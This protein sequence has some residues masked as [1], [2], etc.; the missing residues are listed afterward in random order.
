MM[1]ISTNQKMG[2]SG[3]CLTLLRPGDSDCRHCSLRASALFA[4]LPSP[5]IGQFTKHIH[6]GVLRRGDVIYRAGD[7]GEAVFTIRVGVVKLLIE[8]PARER[9]IVR[10][11]G[12]GAT[13]GLEALAGRPYAHTAVALR[14]TS[15]CQIP[16]PT[17][18]ELHNHSPRLLHGLM[19]KWNEQL[20]WA[21]R[22]IALLGS[23]T[24]S[25]R[26]TDL[27][28]LLA[29]ISGD[30]IDAI[31]LPPVADISAILGVSPESVS[32]HMAELKRAGLLTRLAPRTFRC[33]PTLI[34]PATPDPKWPCLDALAG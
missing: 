9:R 16:I 31:Q 7:P 21:D 4:G 25:R 28:R 8:L 6:T 10:L 32:R 12:R 20:V 11:L 5:D 29:D 24:V 19:E 1:K 17:I 33:D 18:D 34:E 26:V 27:I 2:H 22:W 13:L 3:A 14:T 23:G 30:P 15:L